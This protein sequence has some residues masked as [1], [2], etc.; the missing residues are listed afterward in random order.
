LRQNARKGKTLKIKLIFMAKGETHRKEKKK[1]KKV[2]I[3]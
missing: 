2:K 3:K 1:P